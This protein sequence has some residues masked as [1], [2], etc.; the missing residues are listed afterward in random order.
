MGE[1]KSIG[2]IGVGIMGKS[3]VR[4]LMKA[5][6]DLHIYARTRSKVEDVISEGAVFYDSIADCVK[7]R[8]AVVT[9]VGFPQDVEEVY[10]EEGNI[11]DNVKE[12]AYLIDMTTTSPQLAE[13][14]YRE[15]S[16]KGCHVLDAPVTGG[17]TGA[18]AGTLSIL[19]GGD[20]ADFEACMPLFQ[21]MGTNINYQGKAGCGQHCK[22]A[23][24]IMIAGALSGVC[25]AIVYAKEKGLDPDTLLR[26]VS[27]GAAGSRQLD[28]LGPKIV[29]EDFAPGFFMK[30]FIKDMRLAL[31]EANMSGLSL[32]VLSTV[33][34]GCEELEAEGMGDL[35]TQA[36]IRYYDPIE[37]EDEPEESEDTEE[38]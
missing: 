37:I 25:E 22:L 5:G 2:F 9:I 17:D 3:M 29:K 20:E 18:K 36:L 6:F 27:S 1:I 7:E 38:L 30:H 28:S 35:G 11:L 10:F 32:D 14:I 31:I 26:S 12:G 34:A 16:K 15:G 21:A 8:D 23:N 4:N 13:K 19:A 24:Q 33:L